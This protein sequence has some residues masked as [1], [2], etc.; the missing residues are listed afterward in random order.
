MAAQN[1]Q[2]RFA[3]SLC[4]LNNKQLAY[5][6]ASIMN[7][8]I[9]N[10][11]E[12][13]D[14]SAKRMVPNR[15]SRLLGLRTWWGWWGR[16]KSNLALLKLHLDSATKILREYSAEDY[17]SRSAIN[18][19]VLFFQVL[20]LE[21]PYRLDAFYCFN[22]LEFLDTVVDFRGYENPQSTL[23]HLIERDAKAY[24]VDLFNSG[25]ILDPERIAE[26]LNQSVDLFVNSRCQNIFNE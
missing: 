15:V 10:L 4:S 20:E 7:E 19:L 5:Y 22:S 14:A 23:D 8:P 24:V 13:C 12:Y 26:E 17:R 1:D 18:E 6:I 2:T 21:N 11:R 25:L 3:K 9:G 16:D